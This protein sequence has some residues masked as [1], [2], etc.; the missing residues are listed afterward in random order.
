MMRSML[1]LRIQVHFWLSI[2][3]HG[4]SSARLLDHSR[5]APVSRPSA[6]REHTT[7]DE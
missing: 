1:I 2:A 3:I 6:R 4:S 7:G 5:I